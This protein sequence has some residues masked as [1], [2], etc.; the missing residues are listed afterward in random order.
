MTSTED[1][2]LRRQ[3]NE[4]YTSRG[5]NGNE[6]DNRALILELLD[7]RIK[8]ARILGYDTPA[9]YTL[10]NKM[11][12]DPQTVDAFLAGIMKAA[13]ATQGSI[14]EPAGSLPALMS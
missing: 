3:Y 14:F 12:H 7:K 6:Y 9:A 5:H 2:E 13:V 8:K 10:A 1:R 4:A 11:A